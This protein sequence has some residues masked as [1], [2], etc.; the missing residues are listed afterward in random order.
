MTNVGYQTAQITL[1]IG[2]IIEF[3]LL[4]ASFAS[5]E[6]GVNPSE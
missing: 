5:L 6:P 3:A 4:K 2:S 1:P